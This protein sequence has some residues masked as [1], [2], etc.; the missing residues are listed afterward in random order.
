MKTQL[1]KTNMVI[2]NKP[3]QKIIM[4]ILL[5]KTKMEILLGHIQKITTAIQFIH[6]IIKC[7][8]TNNLK[9]LEIQFK[10]FFVQ[11]FATCN[12]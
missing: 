5:S 3:N 2:L 9:T 12:F 1:P 8:Q 4:E 11:N 6:Q 10:S 7:S